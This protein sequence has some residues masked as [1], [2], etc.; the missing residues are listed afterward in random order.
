MSYDTCAHYLRGVGRFFQFEN[1]VCQAFSNESRRSQN[2]VINILIVTACTRMTLYQKIIANTSRQVQLNPYLSYVSKTHNGR[3]STVC[4]SWLLPSSKVNILHVNYTTYVYKH[5][6][7]DRN[8][9]ANLWLSVTLNLSWKL[10]SS[11]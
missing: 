8:S 10:F 3:P 1:I 9:D 2:G 7:T 11:T 5:L 6:R 4:D